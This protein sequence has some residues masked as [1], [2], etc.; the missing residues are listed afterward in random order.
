[1]FRILR[2][3]PWIALGALGAWLFDS[4]QGSQ[5]RARVKDNAKRM[6]ESLTNSGSQG[7]DPM[8]GTS[9]GGGPRDL[10]APNLS[11]T[12][13]DDLDEIGLDRMTTDTSLENEKA[14]VY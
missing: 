12:P 14:R 11:G 6:T 7:F 10:E 8:T 13:M 4:Q 9:V 5:R 1:M 3:S 2:R